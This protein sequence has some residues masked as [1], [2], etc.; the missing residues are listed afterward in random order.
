MNT[1]KTFFSDEYAKSKN[2]NILIFDMHNLIFRTLHVA[3]YSYTQ[4][5]SQEVKT[6]FDGPKAMSESDMYFYWKYLMINSIFT[7]MKNFEPDK[8]I[9]AIDRTSARGCA[10]ADGTSRRKGWN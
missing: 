3:N 4:S 5:W 2:E 10:H 7:A 8:L 6:G 9:F 1:L